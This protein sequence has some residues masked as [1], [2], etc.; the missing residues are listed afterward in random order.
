MAQYENIKRIYLDL[1]DVVF[2]S[3]PVIQKHVAKNF[4]QFSTEQLRLKEGNLLLWEKCLQLA[5]LEIDKAIR[6]NREPEL[7]L[8]FPVGKNDIIRE[9]ESHSD[10]Y[11][12]RPIVELG[13]FIN[14]QHNNKNYYLN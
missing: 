9:V 4:P 11:D 3:S 1:D 2:N 7:F 6:E 12:I 13:K 5:M 8:P 10:D 14:F